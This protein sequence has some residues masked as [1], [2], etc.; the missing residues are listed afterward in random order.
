MIPLVSG[1]LKLIP[2]INFRRD[3]QRGAALTNGYYAPQGPN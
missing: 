3:C 2:T 1:Q